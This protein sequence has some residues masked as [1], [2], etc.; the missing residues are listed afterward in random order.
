LFLCSEL[1]KYYKGECTIENISTG[2]LVSWKVPI[3]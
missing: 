2:A 1:A 3:E